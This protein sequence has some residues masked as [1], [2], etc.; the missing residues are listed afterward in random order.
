[1]SSSGS[2]FAAAARRNWRW[3]ALAW[4]FPVLLLVGFTAERAGVLPSLWLPVWMPLFFVAFFLPS[5]PR[6]RGD[7]S[8]RETVVLGMLVPF[9]IWVIA[10]VA[11]IILL[12]A[13]GRS[14][15][16]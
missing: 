4:A 3:Y 14:G 12:A 13:V 2:D 6:F 16:I 5:V 15:L 1:M 8:Y 11:R 7:A 10:V 9:L